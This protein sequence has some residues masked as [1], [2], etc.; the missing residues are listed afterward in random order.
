LVEQT[1]DDKGVRQDEARRAERADRILDAAAA[2]LLRWGY[3]KTTVDDIARQAGVAKGTVYLHWRSREALFIALM[4]RERMAMVAEIR[5]A[6]DADPEGSTLHGMLRL[7]ALAILR[8]PLVKAILLREMDVVGKL[9]HTELSSDMRA[10][11]LVFQTYLEALREHGLARTD[12]DLEEQVFVASAIFTGFLL[13]APLMPDEFRPSDERLA[14][15]IAEAT[16]RVLEPRDGGAAE[17]GLGAKAAGDFLDG[18]MA[19]AQ[20]LMRRSTAS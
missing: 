20:D 14:A 10:R 18:D 9:A 1:E 8:R 7:S 3:N 6:I 11:A 17:P 16:R 5:Q 12:L 15:L 13:V 2:L 4:V 19:I